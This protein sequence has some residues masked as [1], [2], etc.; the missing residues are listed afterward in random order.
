M[1]A[2]MSGSGYLSVKK[3]IMRAILV[4]A[5]TIA[6]FY[7]IFTKVDFYSVVD[8]LSHANV[9]YL[10][11]A[12][13]LLFVIILITAKRWQTIL[14][15]ETMGCNFQYKFLMAAF[16]LTSITPSKSGDVDERFVQYRFC[17]DCFFRGGEFIYVKDKLSFGDENEN[18]SDI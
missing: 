9:F 7:F 5:V 14:E 2:L 6:I 3:S 12:L 10:F 8:I 1:K 16:P 18:K 13:L 17:A 11:I 4:L 15:L